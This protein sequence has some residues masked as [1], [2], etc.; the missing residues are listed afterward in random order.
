MSRTPTGPSRM[1][2]Q[3]DRT[4]GSSRSSSSAHRIS[5]VPA[6]GSSSVLSSADC[7]SSFMR[8]AS[9]RTA[10][11]APPSTGSSASSTARPRTVP[12]SGW[13]RSP[14]RI[15]P[16]APSGSRRWRSGWLPCSTIRQPRHVRHGRSAPSAPVHR[17]AAAM[18]IASGSLPTDA[19]PASRMAC[20]TR[21]ASIAR[22]ATTAAGCPTV[23]KAFMAIA[24]TAW[25]VS[26]RRP[27]LPSACA[28]RASSV[29][30]PRRR[31]PPRPRRREPRR[32]SCD[33]SCASP[34]RRHRPAPR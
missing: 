23:A 17:S 30:A 8:C 32:P 25:G 34:A 22:T 4:V 6:G 15:W 19:G 27:R 9:R 20:G 2:A 16:P 13:R 28:A 33:G 24:G 29:P 3:R 7:A 18:S 12:G 21:V 10:T 11:R 14:M 1:R 5:V 26:P 31:P